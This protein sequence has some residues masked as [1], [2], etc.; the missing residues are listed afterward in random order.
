M[1]RNRPTG[2][3]KRT[4]SGGGNARRRGSGLGTGRVGNVSKRPASSSGGGG[5]PTQRGTQGSPSGGGC[6]VLLFAYLLG[7]G[8]AGS[9]GGCRNKGCLTRI[10]VIILIIIAVMLFIQ[11]CSGGNEEIP[12]A[13]GGPTSGSGDFSD[14][15]SSFSGSTAAVSAS[16]L[17]YRAHEA[18]YTVSPLAREK[19]TD[20]IGNGEDTF[21]IMVYICGSDLE[22]RAGLATQDLQEMTGA[23]LSENI[24]L[25]VETGGAKQW[26]NNIVDAGSNQRFQVV[27]GGLRA[28]DRNLGRKSMVEPQTLAD[29]ISFCKREFPADRYALIFW[30]HGGGS[31]SGY[32]YDEQF[33]RDS[34]TLDEI[35][36]ALEQG[37]CD[38]DFIGFDA[39]LMASLETALVAEKYA[40]YLIAS[41]AVEPG[42]GWYYTDW[43]NKLSQNTSLSTVD[44]GKLIIDDY[45]AAVQAEGLRTPATLSIMDLAEMSG[46]LPEAFSSFSE[47]TADLIASDNYDHVSDAR[48]KS[49]DF[50]TQQKI[51]QIDLIHFADNLG[52]AE[53]KELAE[54]LRGSIK[55][56]RNSSNITHANGVSIYF[57]YQS[58]SHV[59]TA[60]NTYEKIGMDEAYNDVIRDFASMTAGGSVAGGGSSN[61]L[62][63]LLGD[64]AGSLFASLF[65]VDMGSGSSGGSPSSLVTSLI[66]AFLD[67]G[68]RGIVTGDSDNSWVNE[69]LLEDN[70]EYFSEYSGG[71]FDLELTLNDAG[72]RVLALSEEQWSLVQTLELNVF[73][74]D[75]EGYIDLGLDNVFD[76]DDA[77]NLIMEYD[78]SWLSLN[79][80]IVS[81][82]FISQE[83]LGDETI[84]TGYVPALLNGQ[85][86]SII[87]V[88]DDANPYGYVAGA[89]INYEDN[90]PTV[91]K[92]LID[93]V[94]GDQIDFLCD[95][96][97]YDG[98]YSDS[99]YLGD[100]MTASGD[101]LIGNAPLGNVQYL[102]TYRITDIYGAQYWTPV[103]D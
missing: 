84:I 33:P 82:Y 25:I 93:I 69:A 50:S 53:S 55:Y 102:M 4:V 83:Q 101:W 80:Q 100:R 8:T 66:G 56:N 103:V 89:Q 40:D 48:S 30:D 92:G 36:L 14:L 90:S 45:V 43:L 86:V 22:S 10:F 35:D 47:G 58:L 49:R 44:I 73:L 67:S 70:I 64:S 1:N 88:F 65:G 42:D 3:K 54:V 63:T 61:P 20:V 81:Y 77:G 29:F 23:N 12:P 75:G 71:L 91:M 95:F 13:N 32:G 34:M 27:N 31:I 24:N 41:E 60:I 87:V 19:R 94:A 74:D 68:Q 16:D 38:F 72:Q 62:G 15:F 57:P 76:W 17:A 26:K 37:G 11:F 79:G 7:R 5:T 96:Y 18:D 6:L 78:A 59:S 21:T 51:N 98:E 39:C 46:T 85:R 28:L 2:R 52:T 97:T 9:S 99:Y